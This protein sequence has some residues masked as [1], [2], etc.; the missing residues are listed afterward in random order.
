MGSC[1]SRSGKPGSVNKRSYNLLWLVWGSW[2]L[3]VA[4]WLAD[5][6][7][8]LPLTYYGIA[9]ASVAAAL[10]LAYGIYLFS[11]RFLSRAR[12]NNTMFS[13]DK[14]KKSVLPTP[15]ENEAQHYDGQERDRQER[16]GQESSEVS[17]PA[18]ELVSSVSSARVKK[19]T[20]ISLGARLTGKVACDA[21]MTVEG[22]IEG[23]LLCDEC[24][25]IEH[26]GRVNGEIRGQQVVINGVVEGRV[27]ANSITILAQGKVVGDIFADELS[28][29]KGGVFTGMSSILQPENVP[30]V[31]HKREKPDKA[32]AEADKGVTLVDDAPQA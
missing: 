7:L 16:D 29:E 24:V 17:S 11:I 30:Q 31:E 28:I 6:Y 4:L 25:K 20:F 3:L 10:T 12:R 21:N 2:A 15:L 1:N 9:L 8:Q 18:T 26:S 19:D 22:H 32:R 5:G 23:D 14:N 13:F 27:Y